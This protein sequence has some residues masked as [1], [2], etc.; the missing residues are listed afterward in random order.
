[1]TV[2]GFEPTYEELKPRTISN[3]SVPIASF[4]PTYEELKRVIDHL[5]AGGSG[6][7]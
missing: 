6:K 7:F 2:S 3:T 4:E 5:Q 1:M